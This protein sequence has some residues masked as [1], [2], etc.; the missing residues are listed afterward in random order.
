MGLFGRGKKKKQDAE[1]T[2]PAAPVA[3]DVFSPFWTNWPPPSEPVAPVP[4]A[5]EPI[6]AELVEADLVEADLVEAN[7]ARPEVVVAEYFAPAPAP[8]SGPNFYPEYYEDELPLPVR[9]SPEPIEGPPVVVTRVQVLSD[10]PPEP[11]PPT[12]RRPVDERQLGPRDRVL[13]KSLP[14]DWLPDMALDPKIAFVLSLVDG[15]STIDD[16]LDGCGLD[17]PEAVAILAE[18]IDE[19]VLEARPPPP[20]TSRPPR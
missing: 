16:V 8:P 11:E 14:D 10:P 13:I 7:V 12:L 6:E 18:L 20:R 4:V 3:R 19:S 5:P 1:A 17:R 15:V 9:A 2:K